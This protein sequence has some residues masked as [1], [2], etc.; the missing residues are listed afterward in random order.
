M[1]YSDWCSAAALYQP[2]SMAVEAVEKVLKT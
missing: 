2:V 1:L